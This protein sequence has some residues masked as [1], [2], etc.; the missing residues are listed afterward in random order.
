MGTATGPFL[1]FKQ[2]EKAKEQL[3]KWNVKVSDNDIVIQVTDQMYEFDWFSEETMVKWKD[4]KDNTKTWQVCEQFF[5]KA[6]IARKRYNKAK[7]QTQESINNF[8]TNEWNMYLEATE[9][10]A[11]HGQKAQ[12]EHIQHVTNWNV[13]LIT[14][15]QEQQQKWRSS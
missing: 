8:M 5:E 2:I 14:M 1:Y 10:K 11:M 3:A 13:N 4:T 12:Q 15:V 6:Y 7:R 9:A